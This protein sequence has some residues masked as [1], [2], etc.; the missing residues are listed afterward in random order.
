LG[1]MEA[2]GERGHTSNI[3]A[4]LARVFL[5]TNEEEAALAHARTGLQVAQETEDR[6]SLG[7]THRVMGEVATHL[8]SGRAAAEPGFHFEES[9][10]ILREMGAEAELA[11]SLAAYGLYLMRSTDA[12]GVRRGTALVD[13]ARTL[14]RRLGMAGDLT[15]LEAEVTALLQPG[16]VS[17][18]L[19]AAGAP[20]GRPLREDEWVE[21]VW[22]VA[23]LEDETIAGKVARRR[24][25]LLRLLREAKEQGAAPTVDDLAAALEVS[26]ATIKRDLAALRRAGH[27][28]RT[29]GSRSQ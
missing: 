24:H 20:T 23:A 18:R 14:F 13:E 22:T 1:V 28:V 4:Y 25:R 3:H 12:D 2:S 7:L 6:W 8:G 11:R 5:A 19:P 10:R 29:R 15:W 27:E 21:V 16:R 26:R 17:V 9:V